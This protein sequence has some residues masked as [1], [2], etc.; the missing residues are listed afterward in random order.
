MW[1]LTLWLSTITSGAFPSTFPSV[2]LLLSVL[3]SVFSSLDG[4]SPAAASSPCAVVCSNH[5]IYQTYH[6]KTLIMLVRHTH[7]SWYMASFIKWISSIRC[8]L[9]FLLPALELTPHA[10]ACLSWRKL[11]LPSNSSRT[12]T[13]PHSL[14]ATKM[15]W[16]TQITCL[17]SLYIPSICA[18]QRRQSCAFRWHTHDWSAW[19]TRLKL[20]EPILNLFP[21]SYFTRR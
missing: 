3:L 11:T 19:Q 7:P 21:P 1:C 12:V 13:Q 5:D 15:T 17:A 10:S 14:L 2:I 16:T 6:I 20:I 9:Y 8:T 4:T 18:V